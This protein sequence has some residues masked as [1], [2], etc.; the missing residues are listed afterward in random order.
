[1]VKIISSKYQDE[2]PFRSQ[3]NN[4]NKINRSS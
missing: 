3:D 1:M 4:E 2:K